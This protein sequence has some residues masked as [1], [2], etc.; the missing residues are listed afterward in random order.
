[1]NQ[2]GTRYRLPLVVW[3]FICACCCFAI[4]TGSDQTFDRTLTQAE[5]ALE[6]DETDTALALATK[7]RELARDRHDVG[8]QAAACRVL[9]DIWYDRDGEKALAFCI[10]ELDCRTTMGDLIGMAYCHNVSGI[11]LKRNGRHYE[12]LK[13]YYES[14]RIAE[15]I[16]DTHDRLTRVSAA[17][18]NIASLYDTFHFYQK[19]IQYYQVSLECERNMGNRDGESL[20]MANMAVTFRELQQ[21]EKS[22]SY[23]GQAL[24]FAKELGDK[25]A[26]VRITNNLGYT[27]LTKGETEKARELHE[28]ALQLARD[29]QIDD[30]LPYIYS[31]MG[32]IDYKMGRYKQSLKY[33]LDALKLCREE[34]LRM[35]IYRNLTDVSIALN[36]IP[37]SAEYFTRYKELL[38]RYYS[39]ATFDK[40]EVLM[41]AFEDEQKNREIQLLKN[42][43]RI[44]RLLKNVLL[45][46][47]FTVLI[48][49][50]W[51][52]SRYRMKQRMNR[53]LDNLSRTDP[54]TGLSN[55][56]DVMEK[57]GLEHLRSC[58]NK[59]P[60]SIC[61]CDIDHFKSVN[62]TFGHA[63][64]DAVLR[65]VARTFRTAIRGT[66]IAGRW[67]GEE[68]ILAFPET[69]L[70]GATET[71]EKL[72]KKN[73]EN[74]AVH[75][76]QPIPVTLTF[77]IARCNPDES[78]EACINR[79]DTALYQGK[80]AGR[81]RIVTT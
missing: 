65:Q 41:N 32:E 60:L 64:G 76:D 53:E 12:A 37:R 40:F 72:R 58:R 38:D 57:L 61:I 26:V 47:L 81:D 49:L 4:D 44:Q 62:D 29:D 70:N 75:E 17:A 45:L 28:K 5:A 34:D 33:Q 36:D 78:L 59:K 19:A 46:G 21:F 35:L 42:E 66:D 18:F 74:P 80:E 69:D 48:F 2:L 31:G 56:R 67:G 1:M 23:A 22:V 14:L 55:R 63:A 9:T 79:A 15:T 10:E 27:Y 43:K 50:M 25:E 51:M 20:A 73:A 68:F 39:P 13:H 8:Q 54:L 77:G 30:M 7:A 3:F 11:L 16:P 52:I 6:A 71:I 24:A